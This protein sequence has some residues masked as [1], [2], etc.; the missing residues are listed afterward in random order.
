MCFVEYVL[1]NPPG[2]LSSFIIIKYHT[3][4]PAC[5]PQ[6]FTNPFIPVQRLIHPSYIEAPPLSSSLLVPRLYESYNTCEVW[7][8]RV[9]L[10]RGQS[11]P[12]RETSIVL[13]GCH[14][15]TRR[16]GTRPPPHP[17]LTS[18]SHRQCRLSNMNRSRNHIV[19][20]YMTSPLVEFIGAAPIRR[21][22]PFCYSMTYTVTPDDLLATWASAFDIAIL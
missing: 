1:H 15:P 10:G 8:R 13:I 22:G 14:R 11:S 9:H 6:S 17:Q 2:S 12:N 4:Q 7:G 3:S 20:G 21:R 16:R 18:R 5:S 19:L